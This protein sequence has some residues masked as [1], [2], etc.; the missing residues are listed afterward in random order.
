MDN[1]LSL[2]EEMS[3]K[4]EMI[5]ETMEQNVDMLQTTINDVQAINEA[6]EGINLQ[7]TRSIR[8]WMFPAAMRESDPN[9]TDDSSGRLGER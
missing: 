4:I 2:T 9:D 8:P 5:T 1:T 6:M 3:R 7:Q